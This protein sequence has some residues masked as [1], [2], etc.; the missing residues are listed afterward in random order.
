MVT[1]LSCEEV[2]HDQNLYG[3]LYSD[4]WWRCPRCLA[5]QLPG[6]VFGL[7]KKTA[8]VK[9]TTQRY[10]ST[11]TQMHRKTHAT[12]DDSFIFFLK[13]FSARLALDR[14]SVSAASLGCDLMGTQFAR[15]PCHEDAARS[16]SSA[17]SELLMEEVLS[18]CGSVQ[19]QTLGFLEWR[20]V[21]G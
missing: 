1:P 20:C 8:Q 21:A 14:S 9:T 10:F 2:G 19:P 3:C 5:E 11:C 15:S 16:S 18:A 4:S 7:E 17:P 6:C 13:C 12:G